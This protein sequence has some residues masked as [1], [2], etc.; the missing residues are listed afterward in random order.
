MLDMV[1][2][3]MERTRAVLSKASWEYLH[4][5]HTHLRLTHCRQLVAISA[6]PVMMVKEA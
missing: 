2:K 5:G 1:S 4:S 6:N 3:A